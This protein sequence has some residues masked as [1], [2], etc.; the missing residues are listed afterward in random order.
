LPL[1]ILGKVGRDITKMSETTTFS[2]APNVMMH[3][4]EIGEELGPVSSI[5]RVPTN[6]G[7]NPKGIS[8]KRSQR[9]FERSNTYRGTI[10]EQDRTLHTKESNDS[11]LSETQQQVEVEENGEGEGRRFSTAYSLFSPESSPNK[12]NLIVFEAEESE[13][14]TPRNESSSSSSVRP[15]TTHRHPIGL[16]NSYT[17]GDDNDI[18]SSKAMHV[19]PPMTRVYG[20][21]D[22]P[23]DSSI[24]IIPEID[25]DEINNYQSIP[26]HLDVDLT[27]YT[28]LHPA[29]IGRLPLAWLA[30]SDTGS[31]EQPLV[32][33]EAREAQKMLQNEL[34]RRVI[35]RQRLGMAENSEEGFGE[36]GEEDG[37]LRRRG[38]GGV[39]MK[40]Y[41]FVDQISS[42]AHLVLS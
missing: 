33:R 30:T 21:L 6:Y 35:G 24:P 40:V 39:K 38:R 22:P 19:E 10:K 41:S 8:R 28:Y 36:D 26:H 16:L 3:T 18:V 25:D 11:F 5:P 32:L 1:D 37:L 4:Q 20:V 29:L 42:W 31:Q 7:S 12:E 23:L 14:E 2:V 17:E 15:S 13:I 27:L 9:T 34:R